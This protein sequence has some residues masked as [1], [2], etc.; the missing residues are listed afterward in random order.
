MGIADILDEAAELYRGNFAL[1]VGIAA[2]IYIPYFLLMGL[3]PDPS[4]DKS[5]MDIT[6]LLGFVAVALFFALV[7]EPIVTGALTY[8]IS[9]RY[10]GRPTSIGYCFRRIL[11][12]SVFFPFMLTI[13]IKSLIV[14]LPV[15]FIVMLIAAVAAMVVGVSGGGVMAVV[16]GVMVGGVLGIGAVVWLIRLWVRF[17]LVEPAF[18]IE[19]RGIGHALR[20]TWYLMG[21][22]LVKGFVVLLVAG[23]VASVVPQIVTMPT[24]MMLLPGKAGSPP[25]SM[26]IT[27]IHMVISTVAFTLMMP[28]M[29]IVTIL[30]YYDIRIR[31][32]GFDLE[33]LANELDTRTRQFNVG[34]VTALPHEQSSPQP[35]AELP[36]GPESPGEG[37]A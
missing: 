28:V 16:M 7:M 10:L 32:E 17:A 27:V 3:I 9:D 34:D 23:I 36:G 5:S 33:L 31:K 4:I 2:V 19:A 24:Q 21:G 37:S 11:R 18:I 22:N 8:A 12:A 20:R 29:S 30:L 25:P 35:P 13:L 6:P 1:L 15:A 26:V 14:G